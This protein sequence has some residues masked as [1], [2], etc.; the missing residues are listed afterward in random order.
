LITATK[1]HT[2]MAAILVTVHQP[3]EFLEVSHRFFI[4]PV[5][6]ITSV[7]SSRGFGAGSFEP[8]YQMFA[9]IASRGSG[10]A[11]NEISAMALA[12][13]GGGPPRLWC[14][15]GG[16]GAAAGTALGILAEDDYCTQP[17][18]SDDRVF[19]G[20]VRLDNRAELAE[21]L[22]SSPADRC[23]CSDCDIL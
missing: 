8:S 22:I 9:L 10:I 13:R 19:V 6:K 1:L 20:Q 11:A 15:E 12:L 5:R 14:D 4:Q 17:F 3:A 16:F 18:V 7:G 2:E 21:A 23:T